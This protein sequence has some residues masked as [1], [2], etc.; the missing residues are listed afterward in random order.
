MGRSMALQKILKGIGELYEYSK[1][2][3]SNNIVA[4]NKDLSVPKTLLPYV[5]VS[6]LS[7]K[8]IVPYSV[9]LQSKNDINAKNQIGESCGCDENMKTDPCPIIWNDDDDAPFLGFSDSGESAAI[10]PSLLVAKRA[11]SSC[12]DQTSSILPKKIKTKQ[13]REHRIVPF[14]CKNV[15]KG[16]RKGV[17]G[18]KKAS[19][20]MSKENSGIVTGNGPMILSEGTSEDNATRMLD[21]SNLERQSNMQWTADLD[22]DL[23]LKI[24][25]IKQ[26]ADITIENEDFDC[27]TYD[28]PERMFSSGNLQNPT[29]DHLLSSFLQINNN[30]GVSLE[31]E[32]DLVSRCSQSKSFNGHRKQFDLRDLTSQ[33]LE[34]SNK[35]NNVDKKLAKLKQEYE[36]K[37]AL[38]QAEKRGNET[39][40]K[41]ILKLLQSWKDGG[42]VNHSEIGTTSFSNKNTG[43]SS[44]RKEGFQQSAAEGHYSRKRARKGIKILHDKIGNSD[45]QSPD[46][47]L[48][49]LPLDILYDKGGHYDS[50]SPDEGLIDSDNFFDESVEGFSLE[51]LDVQLVCLID[52]NIH[53]TNFPK[54]E[55]K[56]KLKNQMEET[57]HSILMTSELGK[58]YKEEDILKKIFALKPCIKLK[59]IYK[60]RNKNKQ[61]QLSQ[62][63]IK[64]E[65][66]ASIEVKCEK[67]SKCEAKH[68][69]F[70]LIDVKCGSYVVVKLSSKKSVKHYCA[71]ICE[72]SESGEWFALYMERKT[73]QEF[74]FPEKEIIYK[75]DEG[76]IVRVLQ[77]PEV[78][79]RGLRVYY[80]FPDYLDDIESLK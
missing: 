18:L 13:K 29:S 6:P 46:K 2:D 4:L 45:S 39:K 36:S 19:R 76:D 49:T 50:Q 38:F 12:S 47:G 53:N 32:N 55:S 37:V 74:I 56:K 63:E 78:I 7:E 20:K 60:D 42:E 52:N 71:V 54:P 79:I 65:K 1:A 75:I 23:H 69:K 43:L 62:K 44:K 11:A 51:S 28:V 8:K 67:I 77:E 21:F 80:V 31:N 33:L 61:E 30:L 26:E 64:K 73:K 3:G 25:S 59:D 15:K 48:K 70:S 5:R 24:E 17:T 34:L 40:M 41:N 27:P 10:I 58:D 68:E 9:A 14:S 16:R 66:L 22:E 57:P 72:K 35:N